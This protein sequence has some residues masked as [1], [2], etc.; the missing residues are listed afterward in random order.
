[1]FVCFVC[2]L[3]V[4][5]VK[6]LHLITVLHFLQIPSRKK[7]VRASFVEG[8]SDCFAM[9]WQ[10]L[11]MLRPFLLPFLSAFFCFVVSVMAFCCFLW[12]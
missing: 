4:L 1:M 6:T 5:L 3:S 2:F 7:R 8:Q 11:T 9:T 12:Y 10:S